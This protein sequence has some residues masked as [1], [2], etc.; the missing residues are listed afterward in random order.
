M[1]ELPRQLADF[2]PLPGLIKADYADFVVEEL[3]LYPLDGQGTHTFFLV[4]KTG[5]STQQAVHDIA[6]ALNV[7]R[8]DI[9]FA[10]L[11][12]ARA[13]TRQWMSVEHVDPERVSGLQIP[14]L[15]V[16][17]VTRHHNKLRL[18][19]LKGNAFTIRVRQ[20]ATDRLADVQDALAQLTRAGV[21][22]YF[23][24]QRF[25]YRGDTWA[26]GKAIVQGH[27]DEA[28]DLILGRPTDQDTGPLR[29]ARILYEQG[30]YA[31]AVRQWP[32][33]FNTERRAL[34]TLDH[35]GGNKRKAW[36]TID[37][38][39]RSFFVSA[40]QSHLFN[41]VAAARM[42]TGLG[43]LMPGDL[44]WRHASGAV[45]RVENAEQEQPRAD[46]FE[47]SP[48]GPLFGYRMTEPAG[49]PADL[50]VNILAGEGL[51]PMSFRQNHL[52]VKGSRRPLRFPLEDARV[53]L[54]AD[55][56]GPY[57]ELRFV[58]PRGCYAT[59][60]LRELFRWPASRAGGPV[61]EETEV[62]AD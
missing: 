10:G 11:K 2:D 42:P 21:P 57:L 38:S 36:G 35:T 30:R 41:L 8:H 17:E 18:G 1:T 37:K 12:D 15:R 48:T 20:T 16:L 28:L 53:T 6:R 26:V 61:G 23:G 4:E 58:L 33:L 7:L 25:G 13:I 46:A 14:R 40:Y 54:G 19:H 22:N 44:A 45:F 60:V 52:R 59:G 56:A 24:T 43:R 49:Q 9:G 34:R 51:T 55:S 39:T 3:P 32:T 62:A 5:L 29:R 50:E 31:Q 47:I 27:P